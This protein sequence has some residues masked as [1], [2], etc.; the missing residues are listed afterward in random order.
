M[1]EN[2]KETLDVCPKNNFKEK[3]RQYVKVMIETAASNDFADEIIQSNYG[4]QTTAEKIAFLKGMFDVEIVCVDDAEG[5]SKE[6]SDRM[7]YLCL[8]EVIRASF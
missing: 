8:L 5:V 4:F 3:K 7:T 6:E 1:N 2:Q